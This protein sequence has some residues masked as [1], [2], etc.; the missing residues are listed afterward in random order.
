[1]NISMPIERLQKIADESFPVPVKVGIQHDQIGD[2]IEV[3]VP[4]DYDLNRTIDAMRV[5]R[6]ALGYPELGHAPL[7]WK[8]E[9]E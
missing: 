5:Y 2:Y 7:N 3:T 8:Y 1:M 4:A 6:E 9:G